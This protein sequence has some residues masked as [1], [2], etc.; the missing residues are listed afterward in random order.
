VDA[1]G[2][3]VEGAPARLALRVQYL[4]GHFLGW[5]WQ[6]GQRTVQQCLEETTERIARHPVRYHAA[7][8]TDTGV[9]ASGQVVHFDT[10]KKLAPETWVRGL[11]SLLPDDIAVRAAAYVSDHWHARFTALW[12][13]YRYCIHNS[14][15]PDLFVRAHSWYYPYCPLDSEAVAAAL[16]TLP[17]HHDF[18]AFRRAGSSRPHSLVHVYTAECTRE[19]EQIAIRVRAN[20]F[21]YGMMRLLVGALV[22]VG[23]GRWSVERFAGLWQA[24]NREQIKYAAPPQGLCLVGV[25]Y[26]DDPFK[27]NRIGFARCHTGQEKPGSRLGN[28]DLESREERPPHAMSP[29][30]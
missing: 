27:V 20:S 21:L 13:E 10:H 18:R 3:A 25:G 4:G 24:G 16:A 11:N 23:S 17:G 8:R 2:G 28:S 29:L 9:H 6:P 19:G 14:T 22:E 1:V 15:V 30:H 26:P 5:Q 7:G 12:R